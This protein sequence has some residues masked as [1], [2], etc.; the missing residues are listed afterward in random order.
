MSRVEAEPLDVMEML[1]VNTST[2][3]CRAHAKAIGG[4]NSSAMSRRS[5]KEHPS[6]ATK[7][8][9]VSTSFDTVLGDLIQYKQTGTPFLWKD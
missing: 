9:E 7:I 6:P 5:L 3:H 8:S 1:M 2:V 4:Y